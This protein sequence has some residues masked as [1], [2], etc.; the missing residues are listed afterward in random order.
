M[1]YTENYLKS[2]GFEIRKLTFGCLVKYLENLDITDENFDAAKWLEFEADSCDEIV[3]NKIESF[4]KDISNRLNCPEL[5][6]NVECT[7]ADDVKNHTTVNCFNVT[8]CENCVL[9]NLKAKNYENLKLHATAVNMTI[10]EFQVW[11]Y[12][13]ISPRV[14]QL[15]NTTQELENSILNSCRTNGDCQKVTSF[16]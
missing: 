12:F 14:K 5:T 10:I 8:V 16:C 1:I 6:R 13:T 2:D 4:Y 9:E 11:K 7:M 3:E 15:V